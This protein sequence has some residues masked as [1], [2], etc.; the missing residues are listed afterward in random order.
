[1]TFGKMDKSRMK[2]YIRVFLKAFGGEPWNE[3]WM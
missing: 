3:P 2:D 1:M